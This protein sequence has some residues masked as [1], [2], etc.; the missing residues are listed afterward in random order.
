MQA[1]PGGF[2]DQSSFDRGI[3]ELT[4]RDLAY[5]LLI[6]DRQLQEA[7]RFVDRHPRQ[8]FVLDHAAKPSIANAQLDPWRSEIASLAERQNVFWKLSGLVT[9]AIWSDWTLK[10]L[11]PYLDV[12][13]EA[14]GRIG[15]ARMSGRLHLLALVENSLRVL[16][17]FQRARDRE[18]LWRNGS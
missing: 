5:D 15:L 2:L 14:F 12:C 1:E 6:R 16:R 13:V 11:R 17:A 10:D 3:A 8:R 18:Y 9:E 7:T 4:R